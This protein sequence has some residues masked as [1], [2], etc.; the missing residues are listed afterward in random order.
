MKTNRY[1][2]YNFVHLQ[3]ATGFLDNYE[4]ADIKTITMNGQSTAVWGITNPSENDLMDDLRGN[5]S[6]SVTV[7]I[8]FTRYSR[9]R[10][11]FTGI[12]R[13]FKR[14]TRDFIARV[15]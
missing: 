14:F 8:V 12:F 10:L 2:I 3:A 5:G 7:T 6:L 4:A 11:L 1:A 9:L 13:A 15:I